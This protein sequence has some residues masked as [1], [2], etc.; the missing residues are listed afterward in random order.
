MSRKLRLICAVAL[1]LSVLLPSL[2]SAQ[3][4][5]LYDAF[6]YFYHPDP[7]GC[8][9]YETYFDV[10]ERRT[11]PE[12]KPVEHS[13]T[14]AIQSSHYDVCS[15]VYS[16]IEGSAVIPASAFRHQGDK[17]ASLQVAVNVTNRWGGEVV[18]LVIDLNWT[19]VS[20]PQGYRGLESRCAPVELA[21]SF[22]LGS[23]ELMDSDSKQG[24]LIRRSPR[25][26]V[27]S[28]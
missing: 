25:R 4:E 23:M 20:D 24:E 1:A 6:A 19:C 3:T 17:A 11:Q 5:D 12:S 14:I 15:D 7:N 8:D 18:P 10:Y 21:G 16:M 28:Q 22:M 26:G 2:A 27:T 9:L 13:T